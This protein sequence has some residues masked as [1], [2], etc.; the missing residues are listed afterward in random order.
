MS[1]E[2]FLLSKTGY[3]TILQDLDST[4]GIYTNLKSITK[5]EYTKIHPTYIKLSNPDNNVEHLINLKQQ[6]INLII[7]CDENIRLLKK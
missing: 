4:I 7:M 2:Y 6:I 5:L 3:N 1:L